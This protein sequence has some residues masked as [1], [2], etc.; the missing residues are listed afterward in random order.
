LIAEGEEVTE[1]TE[2]PMKEM[3]KIKVPK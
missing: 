1:D 3:A 2:E